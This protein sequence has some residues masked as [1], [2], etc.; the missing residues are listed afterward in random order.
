M[1]LA[2]RQAGM[3]LELTSDAQAHGRKKIRLAWH[4]TLLPT[5]PHLLILP[6]EFH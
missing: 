2:G 1:W 3:V 5:R 4:D 6:K